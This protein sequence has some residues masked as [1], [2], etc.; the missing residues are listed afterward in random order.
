MG[1]QQIPNS[2]AQ[3]AG[4]FAVDDGDLRKVAEHRAVD[5]LLDLGLG[6]G[7]ALTDDIELGACALR[8]AGG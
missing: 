4:A 3:R 7:G 6:L 1:A 5:K 2:L 8:F